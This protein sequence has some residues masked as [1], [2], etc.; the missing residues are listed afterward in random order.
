[1]VSFIATHRE[2]NIEVQAGMQCFQARRRAF[3]R[4]RRIV[5]SGPC[6]GPANNDKEAGRSSEGRLD[7]HLGSTHQYKRDNG[8][9]VHLEGRE[10]L[11]GFVQE[12]EDGDMSHG[13][14]RER[15]ADWSDELEEVHEE[16]GRNREE[17][18][19]EA[20]E[21]APERGGGARETLGNEN[22]RNCEC[23]WDVV[24]R[25][26][27]G[28]HAPEGLRPVRHPDPDAFREGVYRHG[29][30]HD[31]DPRPAAARVRRGLCDGGGLHFVHVRLSE[32]DKADSEVEPEDNGENG[33]A[34]G[35]G[36]ARFERAFEDEAGR[37]GQHDPRGHGIADG[38]DALAKPAH[39]QEGHDAE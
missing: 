10:A 13:T 21:N 27:R 23:L 20:G 18:L 4:R 33:R 22:E 17:R 34:S 19:R 35:S 24:Q 39:K 8:D 29:R 14:G 25:E 6:L 12:L 30:H 5:L 28:H 32:L 36:D 37:R 2:L 3:L 31:D 11:L 15:T 7:H 16:V 38:D 1:M 9:E 26:R